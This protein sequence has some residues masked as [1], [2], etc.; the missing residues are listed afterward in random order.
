[1]KAQQEAADRQ[2]RMEAARREAIKEQMALEME[3]MIKAKGGVRPKHH[4]TLPHERRS[5]PIKESQTVG[6]SEDSRRSA[7]GHVSPPEIAL[8][9]EWGDIVDI[10]I[11]SR[12]S[13]H[14][15]RGGYET[16]PEKTPTKGET[17]SKVTGKAESP[18][19]PKEKTPII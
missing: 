7:W 14:T 12:E 18:L 10:P 13:M 8:R 3:A 1:M 6:E 11:L 15:I 4:P 2:T 17:S 19:K 16:V 9:E 5:E